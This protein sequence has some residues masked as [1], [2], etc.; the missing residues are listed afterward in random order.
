MN[1]TKV[2]NIIRDGDQS[3][4]S[5][6]IDKSHSLKD[7]FKHNYAIYCLQFSS[8][9]GPIYQPIRNYS[10]MKRRWLIAGRQRKALHETSSRIFILSLLFLCLWASFWYPS[11]IM[12]LLWNH[13]RAESDSHNNHPCRT[14]CQYRYLPYNFDARPPTANCINES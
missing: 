7:H 11:D 14:W 13:P 4:W 1:H 6:N 9:L 2:P 3:S 8:F 12:G 10:K 5:L